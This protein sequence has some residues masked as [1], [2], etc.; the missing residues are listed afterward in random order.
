MQI[1]HKNLPP[2]PQ[3]TPTKDFSKSQFLSIRQIC[4]KTPPRMINKVD[5]KLMQTSKEFSIVIKHRSQMLQVGLVTNNHND[6]VLVSVITQL[7]QPTLFYALECRPLSRVVNNKCPNSSA[8]IP[9]RH[10][11]YTT[12]QTYRPVQTNTHPL[13]NASKYRK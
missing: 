2:M 8:V 9:L 3:Y 6:D 11:H 4:E 13:S 10:Q 1:S 12:K 7:L 5:T